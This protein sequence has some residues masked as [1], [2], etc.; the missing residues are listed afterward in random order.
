MSDVN[1]IN[2]DVERVRLKMTYEDLADKLGVDRRTVY[3][4]LKNRN[5][6]VAHLIK[7]SDLFNCSVDY[8]L[9]LTEIR[10]RAS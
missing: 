7:M 6:P 1:L 5:V 4:W 9:G 10:K 3:L 8:L 2:I